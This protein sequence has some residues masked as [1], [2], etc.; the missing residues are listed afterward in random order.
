MIP[1]L[2][3]SV[4]TSTSFSAELEREF[5]EESTEDQHSDNS[6]E[7][8]LKKLNNGLSRNALEQSFE[9]LFLNL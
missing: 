1:T 7:S 2:V 3:F 5:K 6:K 4:W 8:V 9:K